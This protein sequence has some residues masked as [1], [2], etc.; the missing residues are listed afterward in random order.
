MIL[1]LPKN[2]G[3][4]WHHRVKKKWAKALDFVEKWPICLAAFVTIIRIMLQKF[5][6]VFVLSLCL[7]HGERCIEIP[8]SIFKYSKYSFYDNIFQVF[9]IL[10]QKSV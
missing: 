1:T 3:M 5:L 10:D 9:N 7:C 4:P 6:F 2:H 8:R